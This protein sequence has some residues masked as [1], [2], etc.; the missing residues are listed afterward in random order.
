[1]SLRRRDARGRVIAAGWRRR[2]KRDGRRARERGAGRGG[3]RYLALLRSATLPATPLTRRR[4]PR[5][6]PSQLGIEGKGCRPTAA[7]KSPVR[8]MAPQKNDVL[9][10]TFAMR[11][12][13]T[14]A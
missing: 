9:H 14:L 1:R 12:L 6:M 7:R 2:R 8:S 10:G 3:G 13:K 11:V 5:I 4:R